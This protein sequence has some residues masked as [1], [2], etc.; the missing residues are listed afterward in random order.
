MSVDDF[1]EFNYTP[2]DWARLL[3]EAEG[4]VDLYGSE[5]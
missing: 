4:E 1:E 3:E 2:E 5:W